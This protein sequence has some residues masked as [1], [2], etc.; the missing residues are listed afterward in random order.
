MV[1][2]ISNDA[3]ASVSDFGHGVI[4]NYLK[5]DSWILVLPS[6]FCSGYASLGMDREGLIAGVRVLA[7][8]PA[9]Y[10]NPVIVSF[11]E[12]LRDPPLK[13]PGSS[14]SHVCHVA[15]RAVDRVSL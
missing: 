10:T 12:A 8:F 1:G 14:R 2:P 7:I 6:L 15:D 13:N 9:R 4:D 11:G 5:F 3:N